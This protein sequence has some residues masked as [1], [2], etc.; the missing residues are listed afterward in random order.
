[1]KQVFQIVPAGS[2]NS[3]Y[4]SLYS[5]KNMKPNRLAATLMV[6]L[7]VTPSL[8]MALGTTAL[9][10]Q[11]N[12]SEY[13]PGDEVK[14][15]GTAEAGLN[16]TINVI[17]NSTILLH[18]NITAKGDGN[19]SDE[20]TLPDNKCGTFTVNATQEGVT[21]QTTFTVAD[22]N[23]R[24]LAHEMLREAERLR[25]HVE[26]VFEDLEEHEVEIPTE[27]E[28]NFTLGF[29]ALTLALADFEDGNYSDAAEEARLAIGYFGDA[30]KLVQEAV[31]EITRKSK[32]RGAGEDEDEDEDDV[33]GTYGLIVAIDRAL[34]YIEKVKATAEKLEDEGYEIDG[35]LLDELDDDKNA[36]I[37]LKDQLRARDISNPDAAKSL[38]EIRGDI[39]RIMGLLHSTAVKA[40]KLEMAER[41]MEKAQNQIRG[42]EEK[43]SRLRDR[44]EA[45]KVV[46]VG[47][48]LGAIFRKVERIRERIGTEDME[49]LL[50]ELQGLMND[51]DDNLKGL[52]DEGIST[53]LREMNNIEARIRVL[54]ATADRLRRKG[55][56]TSDV[57]EQLELAKGL[58]ETMMERLREGDSMEAHN[59]L[60]EVKEKYEELRGNVESPIL[61][62]IMEKFLDQIQKKLQ[63]YTTKISPKKTP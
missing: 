23:D 31:A 6:I 43:M 54:N 47:N 45:E 56:D 19:Y 62:Q 57:D 7:L 36:L 18:F 35:A 42:I 55:E 37:E 48:S 58:L 28:G 59:I 61:D 2:S 16:V 21:V 60:D 39:G 44:L 27:A 49:E 52:N 46:S 9:T 14:I 25:E 13:E 26:N 12:K 63:D 51:I 38:A 20:I 3:T 10:V 5:V 34:E 11:T 15:F 41:F 30:F 22:T 1:M 40:Y 53:N 17:H 32:V 4:A 8:T 33:E 24:D 50:S 29:E